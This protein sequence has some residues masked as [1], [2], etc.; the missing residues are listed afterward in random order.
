MLDHV[1]IKAD[2]SCV[3]GVTFALDRGIC[4]DGL[5]FDP[6]VLVF[7]LPRSCGMYFLVILSY[8]FKLIG[9]YEQ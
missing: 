3:L 8:C 1:S 9:F 4:S 2:L 6:S 7:M 5:G